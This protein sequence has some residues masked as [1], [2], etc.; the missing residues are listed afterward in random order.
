[1]TRSLRK[2]CRACTAAKRRCIVQLPQ[3]PRCRT[4][5]IDCV[6]DL[7]PL[8]G[9]TSR[10][11]TS[12][13][14]TNLS[15]P[16][17]DDDGDLSVNSKFLHYVSS[18]HMDP[19]RVALECYRNP[20]TQYPVVWRVPISADFPTVEYL[21]RKLVDM[22]D[23]VALSQSAP[24]IHPQRK[25]R[26]RPALLGPDLD[27]ESRK[28]TY[29]DITQCTRLSDLLCALHDSPE[30]LSEILQAFQILLGHIMRLLFSGDQSK[31]RHKEKLLGHTRRLAVRLVNDAP[32][33][34]PSNL[35]RWEAWILAESLR[36]AILMSCLIQ[37]VYNGWTRGYCYH[38]LFIQA[39]PF[40]VRPGM[41]TAGSE[42]E[43]EAL[44][45]IGNDK[46]GS[47]NHGA[48]DLVSFREFASSFARA[49]FDPGADNFQ[50][51]LLMA[52]HGKAPVDRVLGV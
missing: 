46:V 43:W 8:M 26:P 30:P 13:S 40:N 6:Y 36:R 27:V 3:C 37:G 20:T 10:T 23:S 5:Q 42:G 4:R 47:G 21:A 1:M 16:I 35:S 32:R 49:P 2:A 18:L 39:L 45:E 29:S 25:P 24:Y 31:P 51:L 11:S 34:M 44:L 14:S 33:M 38:E 15:A 52:H 28:T 19:K 50:R 9:G 12:R 7:E 17:A 22:A 48:T 41:W